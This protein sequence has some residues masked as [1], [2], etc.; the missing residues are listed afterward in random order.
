MPLPKV[1]EMS[2]FVVSLYVPLVGIEVGSDQSVYPSAANAVP[3]SMAT[4]RHTVSNADTN[5]FIFI[6]SFLIGSV[7]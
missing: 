2:T 7:F 6:S 3:V 4:I 1:V 5:F